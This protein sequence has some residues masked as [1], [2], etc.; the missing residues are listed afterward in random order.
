MLKALLRRWVSPAATS[1]AAPR[2]W[3][4]DVEVPEEAGAYDQ[5]GLR[6]VHNHD[7]MRQPAF[8]RAYQ[9]GVRAVGT[10]YNW[11]WRV[12]VVLW[13]AAHAARHEGDFVE[14]GVNRGFLSSAI[15]EYLDWNA[16]S[17]RF[18][19]LDTF[20]GLDLRYVSDEERAGGIEEKNAA[21]IGSGF[22]TF[23]LDAVR[24]NFAEWR[25]VVIVPGSIPE[26][27]SR[28]ESDRI[29]FVSMDLNCTPP[30]VAAME[31]LW[32]RLVPGALVV[33]DDYAY[34]GY[35]PQKVG[36]D[37]FARSRGVTVLSLP[38]GQGLL[39]KPPG[40]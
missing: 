22:Y 28:I 24:R 14:C 32:D 3:P 9:R 29:A 27:L 16:Q 38:T 36:M 1:N 35:R 2:T 13:A 15:M 11:H 12:H 39:I 17:R 7:F 20:S 18:Y 40:G 25:D 34:V 21:E 4:T 26:T 10:D 31:Y 37:A 33:C 8:A 6:S 30:E 5:D 23:D 19:L